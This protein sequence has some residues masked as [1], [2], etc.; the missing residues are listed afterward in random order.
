[1]ICNKC[2]LGTCNFIESDACAIC[3]I[4]SSDFFFVSPDDPLNF[5]Q[6]CV[7]CWCD[8]K[9]KV[10]YCARVPLE[11]IIRD[12]NPDLPAD[13]MLVKFSDLLLVPKIIVQQTANYL[14]SVD[15]WAKKDP[16]FYWNE[17]IMLLKAFGLTPIPC[18][19][20]FQHLKESEG[21]DPDYLGSSNLFKPRIRAIC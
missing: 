1:M 7:S 9:E 3:N 6:A 13:Q 8:I 10:I 17:A 15:G 14:S 16:T 18:R 11:K 19:I 20:L 21:P 2:G 12:I 4:P 5:R